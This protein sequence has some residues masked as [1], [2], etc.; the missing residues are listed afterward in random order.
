MSKRKRGF[1]CTALLKVALT[2]CEASRPAGIS[3]ALDRIDQRAVI[4]WLGKDGMQYVAIAA[5]SKL[6][7]FKLPASEKP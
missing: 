3:F 7:V 6:V 1:G 2:T 4:T 5:G